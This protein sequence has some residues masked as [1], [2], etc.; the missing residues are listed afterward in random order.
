MTEIINY[1]EDAA[2]L[3]AEL[4]N[5]LRKYKIDENFVVDKADL[6]M[7]VGALSATDIER[8]FIDEEGALM[9]EYTGD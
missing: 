3:A 1:D 6:A 4:R 8:V 7:V 2:A 9:I 5:L